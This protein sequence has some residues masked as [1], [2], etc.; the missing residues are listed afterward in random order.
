MEH[1]VQEV[2]SME[3][4][5]MGPQLSNERT[6]LTFMAAFVRYLIRSLPPELILRRVLSVYSQNYHCK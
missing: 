2:K 1:S 6:E 5:Q 3:D 4:I